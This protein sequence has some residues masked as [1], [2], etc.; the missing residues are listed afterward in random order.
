MSPFLMKLRDQKGIFSDNSN[1]ITRY[2]ILHFLEDGIKK[3]YKSQC[4]LW[5]F[6]FKR[7]FRNSREIQYLFQNH[8][9]NDTYQQ[10]LDEISKLNSNNFYLISAIASRNHYQ[11]D[12]YL[13]F[14]KIIFL[15]EIKTNFIKIY[16]LRLIHI[17][18]RCFYW[19][20]F[21]NKSFGGR[22]FKKLS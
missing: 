15:S 12:S 7:W 2:K 6:T 10:H 8:Y 5:K 3:F 1:M 18:W 4:F 11:T 19:R 9:L 14:L 20:L 13:N 21:K 16:I 22:I 17:Y